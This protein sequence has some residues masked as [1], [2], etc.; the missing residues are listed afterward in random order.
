MIPSVSVGVALLCAGCAGVDSIRKTERLTPGMGHEEVRTAMGD[1]NYTQ[2][3]GSGLVWRY[4]L[5]QAWQGY[6][7]LYCI[8]GQ[9]GKLE[10]WIVDEAEY[11]WKR[12]Q[13][14]AEMVTLL[15]PEQKVK[16][17]IDQKVQTDSNVD[18]TVRP[19]VPNPSLPGK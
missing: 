15:P 19:G 2:M 9:N 4:D 17:D 16:V 1:P 12:Q 7:P 3:L 14:L 10:S 6:K 11:R 18:I 5:N 8:F 13:F